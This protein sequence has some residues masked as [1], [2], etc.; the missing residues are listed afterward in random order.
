MLF[1]HLYLVEKFRSNVRTHT[2][3]SDRPT[4][5]KAAEPIGPEPAGRRWAL[6]AGA[7]KGHHWAAPGAAVVAKGHHWAALGAAVVA[8]GH[9]WA[10][11]GATVV[12]KGHHWAA[13]GATVVAEGHHWAGLGTAVVAEGHHWAALGAAVLSMFAYSS[14]QCTAVCFPDLSSVAHTSAQPRSQASN[15]GCAPNRL[16]TRHS[17]PLALTPTR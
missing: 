16:H 9:H 13:L 17:K 1:Q 10:P 5:T 6:G 3:I 11:L 4:R 15:R 8:E 2:L 14:T 7:A 12:A